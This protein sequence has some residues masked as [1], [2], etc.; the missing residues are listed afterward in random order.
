MITAGTQGKLIK[1]G[2]SLGNVFPFSTASPTQIDRA[3]LHQLAIEG[4]PDG[5]GFLD[6]GLNL[7]SANKRFLDWL[8]QPIAT[9]SPFLFH[10]DVDANRAFCEELL[11]HVA[12]D[13][14]WESE[15][16]RVGKD[17][18]QRRLMMR[19]FKGGAS[20]NC[21]VAHIMDRSDSYRQQ[22]RLEHLAHFDVLT[23]LPNRQYLLARITHEIKQVGT[24]K[25]FA[26]LFLDLDRFKHI[27]DTLGH[28]QGD[29]LLTAVAE[30]L[31]NSMRQNDMV[32]RV[33]GDEFVILLD[34]VSGEEDALPAI[35]RL[36]AAFDDPIFLSEGGYRVRPSI[37]V[38]FFPR[39]GESTELLLRHA[40]EAMYSAKEAGRNQV[41]FFKPDMHHELAHRV[42]T[43]RDLAG[44]ADRG[45]FDVVY[46]PI[47]SLLNG[48]LA[49]AEALV[50]WRHPTRGVVL[51][52]DFI[53]VAEDNGLVLEMG[54]FVLEQSIA[55]AAGRH[56]RGEHVC[57]AVN[58]SIRQLLQP[59]L[60][61]FIQH[62]LRKYGLPES[63]LR[64][65][66]TE[67]VLIENFDL[68]REVIGTIKK[69]GVCI[70]LDDFGTGYSSLG[71]LR[72]FPVDIVKIDR[73]FIHHLEFRQ[74]DEHVVC[75]IIQMTHSLG[76][77]VI[78]EGVETSRQV[79]ILK[80]LGCDMVQ[81]YYFGRPVAPSEFNSSYSLPDCL[82]A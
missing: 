1:D 41:V 8:W 5:Y 42:Q 77:K 60:P 52:G 19:V 23:D 66:L 72:Q 56:Q 61:T 51:P 55:W 32:G 58:L 17:H 21:L 40:D 33:G 16:W 64:L 49:G 20:D 27:N 74:E 7:L 67:S 50:R 46:Q 26:V 79:E 39:D 15:F 80:R 2:E 45:E 54:E 78:A 3:A 28:E 14:L 24:S 69:N 75:A 30:R 35:K 11:E 70:A 82:P 48:S 37:G 6:L 44:A 31:R 63:F 68:A 12:C 71:Y 29:L 57:V 13:G 65:E 62:L 34:N 22:E 4:S 53:E 9:R 36:Q 18:V 38:A 76:M 43:G 73:S 81:G 25:R 10:V 47:V 59:S